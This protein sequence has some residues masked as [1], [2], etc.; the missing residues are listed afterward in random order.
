MRNP[1]VRLYLQLFVGLMSYYRYL[2]LFAHSAVKH[3]LCCVFALFFFFLCNICCQFLWIFH[4]WLPLRY[5]ITFILYTQDSITFIDFMKKSDVNKSKRCPKPVTI[6]LYGN[7][8]TV[9]LKVVSRKRRR[10]CTLTS[11]DRF[12]NS[13]DLRL[14]IKSDRKVKS[15][16]RYS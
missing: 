12:T 16:G 11:Y 7:Q 13:Q 2:C 14:T 9:S 15:G 10:K 6:Y 1:S 3:I 5:S 8:A 4:F